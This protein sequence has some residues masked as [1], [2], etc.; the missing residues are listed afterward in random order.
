LAD[1]PGDWLGRVGKRLRLGRARLREDAEREKGGQKRG[2]GFCHPDILLDLGQPIQAGHT[3]AL[4][5]NA[6]NRRPQEVPAAAASRAD[7][8]LSDGCVARG[9]GVGPTGCGSLFDRGDEPLRRAV[10]FGKHVDKRGQSLNRPAFVY[11]RQKPSSFLFTDDARRL[12]LPNDM[13]GDHFDK[14]VF[15]LGRVVHIRPG[16]GEEFVGGFPR[17]FTIG[18]HFPPQP[19]NILPAYPTAKNHRADDRAAPV[20]CETHPR[21]WF[22]TQTR[23]L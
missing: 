19:R 13:L 2:G 11:A 17:D 6:R 8:R 9:L 23:R 20:D 14:E 21:T 7:P 22:D 5:V 16:D 1:H 4:S 12:T 18:E 15:P 10:S 3:K